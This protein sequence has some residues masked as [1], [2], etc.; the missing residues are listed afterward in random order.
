MTV[1]MLGSM[2]TAATGTQSCH[3]AEFC[4]TCQHVISLSC[5][6][7][8]CFL[9]CLLVLL[10]HALRDPPDKM[11]CFPQTHVAFTFTNMCKK[12]W[13]QYLFPAYVFRASVIGLLFEHCYLLTSCC[14]VRCCELWLRPLWCHDW[15]GNWISTETDYMCW[16]PAKTTPDMWRVLAILQAELRWSLGTQCMPL[17]FKVLWVKVQVGV[18]CRP[19]GKAVKKAV[20]RY[21]VMRYIVMRS[22]FWSICPLLDPPM[23]WSGHWG[24]RFTILIYLASWP[25][26]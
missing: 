11:Q 10:L 8:F 9:N 15:V 18:D 16:R 20:L 17:V 2:L 21:I 22:S 7:T 14:I 12:Y 3:N 24:T 19:R 26:D 5:S 1:Y 4:N 6:T 23:W 13:T 25:E